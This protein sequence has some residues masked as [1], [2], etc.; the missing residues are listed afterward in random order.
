MPD[1]GGLSVFH[2]IHVR[3]NENLLYIGK[4]ECLLERH[5]YLLVLMEWIAVAVI[6]VELVRSCV[7]LFI[8][9]IR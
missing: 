1:K 4:V 9:E 7:L 3:I 2:F 5:G 8:S 6:V